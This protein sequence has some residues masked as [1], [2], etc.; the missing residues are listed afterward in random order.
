MHSKSVIEAIDTAPLNRGLAGIDWIADPRNVAHVEG[1]D[2]VLFDYESPGL[3]QIHVLLNSA[4]GKDAISCIK[5]ALGG[6]FDHG[7]ETVFGMV[8]EF[9]RDV[10]LMARWVG[11]EFCGKR[12]TADGVCELFVCRK[13]RLQ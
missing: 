9:R 5:R 6:I 1:D 2:I 7:A 13:D 8:P 11:M 12:V 4:R 3:Y 10:K